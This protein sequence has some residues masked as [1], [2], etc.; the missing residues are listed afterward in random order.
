MN[1]KL[2]LFQTGVL[3]AAL[4]SGIALFAY[5][6]RPGSGDIFAVL[7][8]S[9]L[10]VVAELLGFV[11]PNSARGSIAFI[12]YLACA[13]VVPSWSTIIGVV[14]VKALVE[15]TNRNKISS[16]LLNVALHAL[17]VSGAIWVYT[18]LGGR[19]LLSV[20]AA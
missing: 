11:L 20:P 3:S 14:V 7:L 17:S 13:L 4:I 8:L 6:P 19:S 5:S 18:M 12:P 1:R 16:S 10:A 2:W 9:I 15:A